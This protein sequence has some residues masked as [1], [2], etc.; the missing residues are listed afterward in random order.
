MTL[1]RVSSCKS[2][3][4]SFNFSF[5]YGPL[6]KISNINTISLD[7]H[8][9]FVYAL[10]HE[11]INKYEYV[12]DVEFNLQYSQALDTSYNKIRVFDETTAIAVGTNA[13][14]FTKDGVRPS[15]QSM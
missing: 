3:Y 12:S 9:N 11:K 10:G 5:W 8:N 13:I 1:Y 15:G 6:P 2:S 7:G 14:I 4:K